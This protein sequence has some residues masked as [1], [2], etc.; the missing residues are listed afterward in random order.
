MWAVK[1]STNRH[2]AFSPA[3]RKSAG[4]GGGPGAADGCPGGAGTRSGGMGAGGRERRFSR[5]GVGEVEV[6]VRAEAFPRR[7]VVGPCRLLWCPVP[8][9]VHVPPAVVDL[10]LPPAGAF[11]PAHTLVG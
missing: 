9:E 4:T 2:Q 5:W 1:N 6:G 8:A 7:L 3:S 11:L 10:G